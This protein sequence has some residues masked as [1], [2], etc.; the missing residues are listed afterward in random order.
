MSNVVRARAITG[1]G[2]R[3]VPSPRGLPLLGWALEMQRDLLGTY[4]R[5]MREH[6]DIVRLTAGSGALGQEFYLLFHPDGVQRV[7]ASDYRKYSVDLPAYQEIAH[8]FGNGLASSEG[9]D[10]IRLRRIIQPIF[11]RSRISAYS[12]LM[13]EEATALVNRLRIA[14][15]HG[16]VELHAEVNRYALRV[17]GRLLFGQ[18]WD[19][20]IDLVN[21]TVPV[22]L[23]HVQFRTISPIRLP[24]SFPTPGNRRAARARQELFAALDQIIE[25]RSRTGTGHSDDLVSLLLNARDPETGTALRHSE[26]RDELLIFLVAGHETVTSALTAALHI[27]GGDPALQERLR[28]EAVDV[29]G[30]RRPTADDVSRLTYTMM[31]IKETIR[32]YPSSPALARVAKAPD[33]LVGHDIPAGAMIVIPQWA[34]HR[35]PTFWPDPERFDPERF[36]AENAAG[37]HRYAYLPFGGGQRRCVGEHFALME[38]AVALSMVVRELALTTDP[39]PLP[40]V[41]SMT[42]RPAGRVPCRV[43][44]RSPEP[45]RDLELLVSETAPS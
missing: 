29:L 23:K 37:R 5:V 24:H 32:L 44:P 27:I 38:A 18:S 45:V 13:A 31:T 8:Y 36:S 16:E 10:W 19:A 22:I 21:R 33:V 2:R 14:A 39:E 28:A 35:H 6:G 7:L 4:A 25:E 30:D 11:S 3:P 1:D 40:V 9:E 26:I 34:V 17:V 42:L 41:A 12:D 20:V 43:Q 15:T